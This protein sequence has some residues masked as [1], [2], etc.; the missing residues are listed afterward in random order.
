MQSRFVSVIQI[1]PVLSWTYQGKCCPGDLVPVLSLKRGTCERE[2]NVFIKYCSLTLLLSDDFT[3]DLTGSGLLSADGHD[4]C[5]TWPP[6]EHLACYNWVVTQLFQGW[7]KSC[8]SA[9]VWFSGGYQHWK[10]E[11][12]YMLHFGS[13]WTLKLG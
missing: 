11:I 8:W 12:W 10:V 3:W 4:A 9:C 5:S 6:Q 2:R 13:I 1:Q 7:L